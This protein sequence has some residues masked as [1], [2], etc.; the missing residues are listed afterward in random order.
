[1]TA[2]PYVFVFSA[3]LS[4][5]AGVVAFADSC[6]RDCSCRVCVLGVC[7]TD[8]IC[9]TSCEA[10]KALCTKTGIDTPTPPSPG[11]PTGSSPEVDEALNQ[12]RDEASEFA[13]RLPEEAAHAVDDALTSTEKGISDTVNT[14]VKAA[15]DIVDA[16]K[17][18]E[19][20]GERQIADDKHRLSAAQKR[21]NEGKVVDAVWHWDVDRGK[22]TEENAKLLVQEN[23]IVSAAAQAAAT[24]YGGP[25]GAAAFAAWKAYGASNGDV[26]YA[27][28]VGV[29]AYATSYA[30]ANVGTMPSTT[31][32]EVGKKAAMTG[33]ISGLA[34][35]ASGGT[36]EDALNAFVRGGAAVVVQ[37]GQDYLKSEASEAVDADSWEAQADTYCTTLTGATCTEIQDYV[38]TAKAYAD[39][40]EH[41]KSDRPNVVF[42][43]DGNW[44]ISWIPKKSEDQAVIPAPVVLT[45]VGAGSPYSEDFQ[46][47]ADI[48]GMK[49][50]T[51]TP[52]G[53]I[54]LGQRVSSGEWILPRSNDLNGSAVEDLPDSVIVLSNDVNRH[55]GP[56]EGCNKNDDRPIVGNRTSGEAVRIVQAKRLRKGCSN[57]I[58][59]EIETV[60]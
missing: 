14:T 43:S 20:F 3:I 26:G 56:R 15:A 23:E 59:A 9:K 29:L 10:A 2:Q 33:A 24:Y 4:L 18:I 32:V 50:N 41:L 22:S 47:L 5:G 25:A 51:A 45:Y 36:N 53:W 58:W 11:N 37:S 42:T 35:A 28:K 7:K 17:A 54:Y 38:D 49:L 21:L 39:T 48:T 8:T 1:M 13:K 19:R 34:V 46:K 30:A 52:L 40:A 57:Y 31:A 6:G 55:T 12:A 60:Q 27:I 44:A 16:V